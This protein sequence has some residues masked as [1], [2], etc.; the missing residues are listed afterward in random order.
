MSSAL[1]AEPWSEFSLLEGS[2][3]RRLGA[4][5]G[6][7]RG[8]T[9]AIRLGLAAAA[10]TWIPLLALTAAAGYLASGVAV[11]FR[12][13]FGTHAR[14]LVAIPMFFIAE[15]VFDARVSQAIAALAAGEIVPAAE[16][17]RLNDVLRQ[18][19]RWREAWLIEACVGAL[20]LFV[21]WTGVRSDLPRGLVTW[22]TTAGG[23]LTAAG[24]WYSLVSFPLFQFFL[25]RFFAHVLL[26]CL[27][28]WQLSRLKLN[29]VATH[30]DG[31]G[32]LGGL[33]VAQVALCPFL[34]GISAM[35]VASYAEELFNG[36]AEL[37][38]AVLHLTYTILGGVA[39]FV[40]PLFVF[41]PRLLEVRQQGVLDYGALAERYVRAFD[42][43]WVRGRT[44]PEEPLLGSADIQ[45]LADLS[46]AFGVIA[47][48]RLTPLSMTQFLVIVGAAALPLTPLVLFAVPLDEMILRAMKSFAGV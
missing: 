44:A 41:A 33:G 14:F 25:W 40:G 19:A 36:R 32:G 47:R 43:K 30:P 20:T 24:W 9:G 42:L 10:L 4:R 18:V 34:F 38:S 16:R 11:P 8:R 13:S 45:S 35:L 27:L 5:F 6:L 39:I 29:L 48:M 21:V 3:V 17:P 26:W 46:N 2:P 31:A 37:R 1:N 28:L 15:A 22:R 12:E 23:E 7:P